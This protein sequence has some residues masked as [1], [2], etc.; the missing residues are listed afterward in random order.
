MAIKIIPR[1]TSTAA[2]YRHPPQAEGATQPSGPPPPPTA[3]F[4]AKA[5]AKDA[6]KETRTTREGSLCMLLHHPYICG[7]KSMILYPHHYY[8]VTEYVNGGQML[9]YIISHGRLRE[10]SARKFARQIGSAL[11]YS[12]ANSIV[13]RDLKIENILISKTGNIKIID[14]GLSN[15]YS[16]VSHLSTFCGSLYFAAPE[17]LNAKPYTGPEVDIW[18]FGIV[19]YVLVCG[20]VPFDDQSMPA[21]HAKIKRGQVEYPNWLSAECKHLLSRMLVTVPANRANMTEVLSHPWMTKGYTGPP[22]NHLPPRIPLRL[23]DISREVIEGMVGFEFGAAIDIHAKLYDVLDSDLY[24]AAVRDWEAKHAASVGNDSEERLSERVSMR[25]DL[26]RSPTN[27]RF[28][29][30][31]FYGK[32]LAGGIN[33]AF[34]P[35]GSTTAGKTSGEFS[36]SHN[37]GSSSGSLVGANGIKTDAL[38]PTRGFHPLI[39]IYYLVKEKMEREKIWG[40][41]VF[42][43]STLSLT[44]PP[45]PPAPAQAYQANTG[46]IAPVAPALPRPGQAV[47]PDASPARASPRMPMTPQPRARAPAEEFPMAPNTA[48][49]ARVDEHG[50]A[51]F[52]DKRASYQ[53]GSQSLG[54]ASGGRPSTQ[55]GGGTPRSASQYEPSSPT[56]QSRRSSQFEPRP[57]NDDAALAPTGGSPGGG[58]VRRFG[59]LLGRSGPPVIDPGPGYKGH[60][61]R[62]SISGTGH[63]TGTKTPV[64]N[65]PQVV[66]AGPARSNSDVPLQAPPEGKPVVRSSTVGELSPSRHQRGVSLGGVSSNSS[67]LSYS[68]T[69]GRSAQDRAR[70]ANSG[71]QFPLDEAAEE[72]ALGDESVHADANREQE[73]VGFIGRTPSQQANETTGAKPVW[74]KGLFSVATTSTKPTATIRSDLIRVL[75]RLGV[76]HKDVKGGFECAH[77]PSIDLSSVGGGGDKAKKEAGVAAQARGT[78]RRRASKLLLS[79]TTSKEDTPQSPVNFGGEESQTSLSVPPARAQPASSTSSIGSPNPDRRGSVTTQGGQGGATADGSLGSGANKSDMIVRFEI[80]IVKMPWLLNVRGLQFRRVSGDAWQYQMLAKRVLQEIKL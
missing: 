20:K 17:L 69:V 77:V 50:R 41:G 28:S 44:G 38:D 65:L 79:T 23:E 45:P 57:A 36:G 46:L 73:D 74:L 72:L 3:S 59:S 13:H 60:R 40:P 64:A 51:G 27:K 71:G 14:F 16:P 18:S 48:P 5:A 63:K 53:A 70:M 68:N 4:L 33:A 31:G 58:F 80:F 35:G 26:K 39:S 25:T 22:A 21:L 30:L 10:R 54:A 7:M 6:S 56:P 37:A 8:M 61:Q 67:P 49:P 29:G 34:G 47:E 24:K 75:D 32:K 78:I 76:Q 9:D 19:L 11:E 42:A 15:L 66:E 62:A 2:A 1:Y 55:Y 52:A 12:H 43:S